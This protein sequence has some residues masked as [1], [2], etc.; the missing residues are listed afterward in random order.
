[1]DA[2][3]LRVLE[4]DAVRQRL[5]A[6]ASSSLGKELAEA[7]EPAAEFE[8]VR[9]LLAETTQARALLAG[10]GR[11]PLG[12]VHDVRAQVINASR[13]G[14]LAERDLLEVS[15]TVYASR[16]MGSYLQN[17]D[18]E[19]PFITSQAAN[20]GVFVE[21]E[22]AVGASID[23][24]G[25]VVDT[26]SEQL[27]ALRMKIRRLQESVEQ[28]LHAILHS[29]Q[30]ARMIQDPIVTVR[31]GRY[32]IPIRS[33]YKGGFRGIVHDSSASGATVFMEPFAVVEVNN[34]VR[35]TRSAE[36]REVRRILA[37]LSG[38]VGEV[39]EEI[40]ASTRALAALDLIFARAALADQMDAVDPEINRDGKID[41]IQARHPLLEG[42]V[43]PV[44]IR[45]GEGFQ[46]LVLTGPNTGGK[47]VSLK[48]LGV[49]T[50]MA[51]S[52]LHLPA[53]HGSRIAVFS[54]VF[55][56]IGD[57][58]SIQQ[59]L[60][61]FSSHM[62]QIVKV[63]DS[64]DGSSLV[65]L[66]EIG[67][68]TDPA[69]GSALAKSILIELLR[70]GSRV[71]ATTH[72]GELKAFA[73]TQPGVENASVEFDS[74]TL[75]PTFEVRIG[76]PGS[77]NAFAIASRLGMSTQILRQAAEMMGESQVELHEVIQRAERDQRDLA[78]ERRAAARARRELEHTRAEY[79]KLLADIK[80]R[81]RDLL[82]ESR[83]EARRI[84][85]R[86]KERTEDL[87]NLLR[88]SVQEAR[89]AKDAI[90]REAELVRKFAPPEPAEVASVA[91]EELSEISAEAAEATAEAAEPE[92]PPP[93]APEP[94]GDLVR[95]DTVLVRSVRQR[96]TIL[97]PP[98][99]NGHVQVQVGL[100]RLSVPVSDLSPVREPLLTITRA[101]PDHIRVAA[102][103]VPME[104]HLR[105]LRAE[106][107]VYE[108]DHYLDR[109]AVARHEK[110]RIVH[111][112]GTGAVR[113]AV[114]ERLKDHPL[115][116]SYRLAE[117]GEGDTG[118]TVVELGER[119]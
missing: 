9:R 1:M 110:V 46:A 72:Y 71:V 13:G 60:S 28:R 90:E 84:V 91:R 74:V 113:A 116:K 80:A 3:T 112:K 70:R 93:P 23:N 96:G 42:R 35:E 85:S 64:A 37:R 108:L 27:R 38:M 15:D 18:V 8:Q 79:E 58:Q 4:Y 20:L 67:A 92:T 65:L 111:G 45:I 68:G 106:A 19:A 61:T 7:V 50:L 73:Y 56:D 62:T 12:G 43:V 36:E 47:T 21:I 52:G 44:D 87:L 49:L 6:Q 99:T 55:A 77:S 11:P 82:A 30:H 66:D 86:A 54:K 102:G 69:E 103:P 22:Q 10:R 105:G 26:A 63:L 83:E 109:A 118:V 39:G 94:V 119:E 81:R 88:Q 76:T 97:E 14:V 51:Q 98:D 115:V 100:L 78:E 16:R 59:S 25:E 95:G 53:A 2:R 29:S 33:E 32:C 75:A 40:L 48:T 114:H 107:A 104:L 34:E 101:R 24:R 5:C 17:A 117:V 57:E 89:E 41:L 31:N